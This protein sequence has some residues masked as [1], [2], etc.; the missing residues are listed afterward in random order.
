MSV[1][2][3]R[4]APQDNRWELKENHW[5]LKENRWVPIRI[6]VGRWVLLSNCWSQKCTMPPISIQCWGQKGKTTLFGPTTPT[7]TR[8]QQFSLNFL[9]FLKC[10]F[11]KC[12]PPKCIFPKC[13]FPKC[14][15]PMCNFCKMYLTCV[16]SKLC[17]LILY[18][19]ILFAIDIHQNRSISPF[20]TP[21]DHFHFRPTSGLLS[22]H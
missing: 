7:C 16:S 10:I 6:T 5:E 4:W 12:I 11:P 22:S 9:I 3:N 8:I 19:F 13:I 1:R 15:Y 21:F 18:D 14:F 20:P 2:D 17:E